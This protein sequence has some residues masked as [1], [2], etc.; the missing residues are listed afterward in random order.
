MV[1]IKL[2]AVLF[3][4]GSILP[5]S[6]FGAPTVNV[7][8]RDDLDFIDSNLVRRAWSIRFE[9]RCKN[10]SFISVDPCTQPSNCGCTG[11]R[12]FSC[13]NQTMLQQCKYTRECGCMVRPRSHSPH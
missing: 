13:I 10:W 2:A 5:V 6:V 3:A 4:F 9:P 8:D 12:L 11:R 1:Q 7:Y